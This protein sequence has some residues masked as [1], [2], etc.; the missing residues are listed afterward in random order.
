MKMQT[1]KALVFMVLRFPVIRKYIPFMIA[2]RVFGLICVSEALRVERMPA[3]ILMAV[4]AMQL[5]LS[6]LSWV[7]TESCKMYF[8]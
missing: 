3:S 7:V 5:F 1:S 2:W 6:Q 8:R 4:S